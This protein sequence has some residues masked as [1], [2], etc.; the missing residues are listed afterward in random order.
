VQV[1][2]VELVAAAVVEHQED[3]VDLP[4]VVASLREADRSAVDRSAVVAVDV[5]EAVVSPEVVAGVVSL[6]VDEVDTKRTPDRF[7][8]TT[9]TP[10]RAVFL[11]AVSAWTS[12]IPTDTMNIRRR[13]GAQWDFL[14]MWNMAPC[15][16][17]LRALCTEEL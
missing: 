8:F 1:D 4:D 5:V 14:Y 3:A 7:P 15:W 11:V 16:K 13:L 10:G 2:V 6:P 17:T 9:K 12:R